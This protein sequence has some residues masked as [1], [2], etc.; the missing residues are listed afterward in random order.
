MAQIGGKYELIKKI[1]TGGMAD[2][3]LAKDVSG[4]DRQVAIKI[5]KDDLRN[6]LTA[7]KRFER[8]IKSNA[9]LEHEAVVP[10]YDSGIVMGHPY[11]VMRYMANGS[12]EER[13]R[14]NG[15]IEI[16]SVKRIFERMASAL[17]GVHQSGMVHRDIKPSN[18]LFDKYDA[19]YLSDFGIVKT[20]DGQYTTLTSDT[21][22]LGT[23]HYMSPEQLTGAEIDHRSDIYSLGIVLFQALTGQVPFH[24]TTPH[25]II[26]AHMY[27]NVPSVKEY[28]SELLAYWDAIIQKCTAK[29]AAD[30]YPTASDFS[31]D[32]RDI[33]ENRQPTIA[34]K[35]QF[36]ITIP[37][38]PV[39]EVPKLSAKPAAPAISKSNLSLFKMAKFPTFRDDQTNLLKFTPQSDAIV[40]IHRNIM[41]LELDG[42][43]KA[44]L[45]DSNAATSYRYSF[46]K[47]AAY[48]SSLAFLPNTGMAY[49]SDT[50][51]L[52][53]AIDLQTYMIKAST[54]LGPDDTGILFN[55]VYLAGNEKENMLVAATKD[56][57]FFWPNPN[58]SKPQWKTVPSSGSVVKHICLS[59]DGQQ[60]A[61]ARGRPDECVEVWDIARAR[62]IRTIKNPYMETVTCVSFDA[63]GDLAF[64]DVIGR[65]YLCS[66]GNWKINQEITTSQGKAVSSIV[67]SADG[68]LL[69][70]GNSNVV[71]GE[72]IKAWDTATM[73][74]VQ[75]MSERT[76]SIDSIALSP[77][78]SAL[79]AGGKDSNLYLWKP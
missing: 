63:K 71:G 35:F 31:N 48:F 65:I 72:A 76:D 73:K 46:N 66:T 40:V 36:P 74:R 14:Q 61:I 54:R 7:Q 3:F 43:T 44:D 18:I 42:Q 5:L 12:L 16:N 6:D 22:F 68:T 41:F 20:K 23:P 24:A 1:G 27:T 8:E 77:N 59:V 47:D 9:A 53:Y 39:V 2:V 51:G 37:P 19:A 11:I 67:F 57:L 69:F 55:P 49:V 28:R 29:K 56:S 4:L 50:R 58:F 21:T 26:Y 64:G 78:G 32:L 70:S 34:G 75:F 25:A 45:A 15:V 79:V 52:V 13:I 38:P 60:L 10:V 33:Y 17:S 30:R 62:M